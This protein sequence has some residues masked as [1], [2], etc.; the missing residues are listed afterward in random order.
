MQTIAGIRPGSPRPCVGVTPDLEISPSGRLVV[1]CAAA[2]LDAVHAAGAD[3]VVLAPIPELAA[4]H[5]EQFDAFVFTGGND[6]AMEVFG[7][8]T[9]PAATLV[10]PR[11]QQYELTLLNALRDLAP[12]RPVLGICLGMQMMSLHAGG[13][14]DQHLPDTLPSHARHKNATHPV[15]AAHGSAR[16]L[17]PALSL[18]PEGPHISS[19]GSGESAMPI[20]GRC[21]PVTSLPEAVLVVPE[22][23][24]RAFEVQSNH[25][26][27]VRDS[28][29]LLVLARSDDGVIEAVGDPNRPFYLGVQWHPER[30]GAP[31]L[32]QQLFDSLVA[33]SRR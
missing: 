12:E 20:P 9:H 33:A 14:L 27:A 1:S 28:G 25:H 16:R 32:G 6:P 13:D 11:R 21:A 30:T 29:A 22:C 24:P 2:Y 31:T 8:A 15:L 17:L 7:K 4:S 23:E 18:Q 3:P 5:A 26:Q 19:R 10:H